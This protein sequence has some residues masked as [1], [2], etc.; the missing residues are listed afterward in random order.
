VPEFANVHKGEIFHPHARATL[1]VSK[2]SGL[3]KKKTQ[4]GSMPACVADQDAAA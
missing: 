3:A 1:G 4:A 2:A